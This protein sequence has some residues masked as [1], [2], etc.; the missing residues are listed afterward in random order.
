MKDKDF[1]MASM[2]GDDIQTDMSV[3]HELKTLPEYFENVWQS[4]KRFEIRKNDRNYK[5]GDTLML[6]EYNPAVIGSE[7]TGSKKRV[8]VNFILENVP[9][10]GLQVGYCIMGIDGIAGYVDKKIAKRHQQA[11]LKMAVMDSDDDYE[12]PTLFCEGCRQYVYENLMADPDWCN[13]CFERLRAEA[14]S[15]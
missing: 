13:D 2:P 15:S 14:L 12:E 11:L 3:E 7:F 4:R 5:V 1:E 9:Q 8:L 6:L 10:L